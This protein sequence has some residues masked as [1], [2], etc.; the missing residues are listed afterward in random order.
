M[1]V[2]EFRGLSELA[3]GFPIAPAF[4]RDALYPLSLLSCLGKLISRRA[5]R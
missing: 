5:E 4:L 2:F 3:D 1:Y